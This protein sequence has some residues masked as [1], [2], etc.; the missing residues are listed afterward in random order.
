M[1]LKWD[2]IGNSLSYW[3]CNWDM[4]N[5]H[6]SGSESKGF[7]EAVNDD[8]VDR[9]P[10]DP[11]GME[12]RSTFAAAITGWIHDVE[13]ELGSDLCVF[14]MQDGDENKITDHHRLF[15][16][17]YSVW[18]GAVSFQQEEGNSSF[19]GFGSEDDD[20]N[21]DDDQSSFFKGNHRVRNGTLSFQQEEGTFQV[22]EISIPNE[23]IDGFGIGNGLPDGGFVFN[24]EGNRLEG[25]NGVSCNDSEGDAPNNALFFTLGYLGVKD[26]LVMERV[27]ISLRD[28]VRNDPLLWRN[29][30]IEDSLSKRIT[31]DALLKLTSRA[32]G[33]IECLSLVGCKMITDDGLKRVLES[34]SKL[35][36]LSVPECTRLNVEGILLNLRA[37]KSAGFPGIKH[38]R[39]GGSFSVTEEQFKELKLLL[40]I[41]N[42]MQLQEQKPQFFRQ[43]QSHLMSDDDRAI[44]IEVC[45]R[46]QKLKLV[47]DCPSES[48]RRTYHAAQLCRACI[49]CIARCIHC[50][51]CFKDCDYE[52]TFTL[53]LL[54]FNC[55]KQIGGPSSKHVLHETR[56]QLCFHG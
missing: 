8:I 34:N 45:P 55:W 12:I 48:C 43:G 42:S 22:D 27:C 15:K 39:I 7:S 11:F 21:T 32:Q 2:D 33:T 31:D 24:D 18:N 25:C 16:G 4:E 19:S 1:A 54:C 3:S 29:I 35:S 47:Y 46:C 10:A 6:F 40:G 51:C 36:K 56:N 44:D 41:N 50:G 28:A 49:L 26:L 30:H 5:D 13:N 14:G 23:F 37:F 20:K 53:D 52:E 38:L 17:L 9:L